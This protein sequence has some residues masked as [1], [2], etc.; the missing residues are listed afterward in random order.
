MSRGHW[1]SA[2]L[3]SRPSTLVICLLLSGVIGGAGG[4]NGRL[5]YLTFSRASVGGGVSGLSTR[6]SAASLV[7]AV[8]KSR[9]LRKCQI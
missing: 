8:R 5:M 4:T 1:V 6:G 9:G 7:T 3:P 2:L